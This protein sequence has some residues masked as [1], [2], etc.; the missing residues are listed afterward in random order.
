MI[1]SSRTLSLSVD[2]PSV[3]T[4]FVLLNMEVIDSPKNAGVGL[5]NSNSI[6]AK[7][8]HSMRRLFAFRSKC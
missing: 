3:V 7:Y 4:I 6:L 2:G 8:M 5:D 1:I